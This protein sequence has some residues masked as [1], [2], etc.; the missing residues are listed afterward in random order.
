MNNFES[1]TLEQKKDI[2]NAK[3]R[4]LLTIIDLIAGTNGNYF[5]YEPGTISE[6]QYFDE[7]YKLLDEARNKLVDIFN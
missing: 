5:D 3:L 2:L 1:L 6:S 7:E 4:E